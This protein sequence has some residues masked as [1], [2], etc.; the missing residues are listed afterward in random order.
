M[1]CGKPG[2]AA[3][4]EPEFTTAGIRSVRP[5]SPTREITT[6]PGR[7]FRFEYT[8]GSGMMMQRPTT[9]KRYRFDRPGAVAERSGGSR[10]AGGRAG[11][12][13]GP[14]AEANPARPESGQQADG[15]LLSRLHFARRPA[16]YQ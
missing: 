5:Q 1:C 14:I 12:E 7:P 10:A 4:A 11:P 13:T 3:D 6:A 8:G 9:G 15:I 16:C 2:K